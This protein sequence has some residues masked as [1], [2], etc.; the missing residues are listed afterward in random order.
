MVKKRYATQCKK[1][2]LQK[3][4]PNSSVEIKYKDT[5]FRKNTNCSLHL[6]NAEAPEEIKGTKSHLMILN[7]RTKQ[8]SAY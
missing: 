3:I 6:S 1:T 4:I 7:D 8:G 5:N 2:K